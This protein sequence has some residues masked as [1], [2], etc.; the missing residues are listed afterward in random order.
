VKGR[1]QQQVDGS[2]SCFSILGLDIP[3]GIIIG[4]IPTNAFHQ[5]EEASKPIIRGT[6]RLE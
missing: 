4:K 1:Q 6:L 3:L 2:G 5:E